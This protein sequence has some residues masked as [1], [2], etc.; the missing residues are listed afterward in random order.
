MTYLAGLPK[1]KNRG[2]TLP[3]EDFL[4]DELGDVTDVLDI[5]EDEGNAPDI[6]AHN[7]VSISHS[8]IQGYKSAIVWLYKEHKIS[9][10]DECNSWSDDFIKGY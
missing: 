3:V 8:T 7:Q 5:G 1:T 4:P 10:S 6:F 9:L 2:G